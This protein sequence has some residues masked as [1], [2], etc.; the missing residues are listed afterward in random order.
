M[1]EWVPVGCQ[2]GVP[3]LARTV[4]TA[5]AEALEDDSDTDAVDLGARTPAGK[6]SAAR[7]EHVVALAPPATQG[8]DAETLL[9]THQ[10]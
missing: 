2:G 8:G 6:T 1:S 5:L 4:P 9:P 7:A 10:R 3:W